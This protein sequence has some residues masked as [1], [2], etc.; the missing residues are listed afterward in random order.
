LSWLPNSKLQTAMAV[1]PVQ[2]RS[3]MWRRVAGVVAAREKTVVEG[4]E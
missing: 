4:E 2:E 1:K 3:S